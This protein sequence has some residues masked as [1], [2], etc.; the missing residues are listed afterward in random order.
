MH[1]ILLYGRTLEQ[2]LFQF[3]RGIWLSMA[4]SAIILVFSAITG[5]VMFA[6]FYDCDPLLNKEIS[7]PDQV[8]SSCICY[9]DIRWYFHFHCIAVTIHGNGCI[10]WIPRFAWALHCKCVFRM[11]KVIRLTGDCGMRWFG[12]L[13]GWLRVT[14]LIYPQHDVRNFTLIGWRVTTKILILI[15]SVLAYRDT[16]YWI[17]RASLWRYDM[18]ASM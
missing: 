13:S 10:P 4:A 9:T 12:N 15:F 5:F 2:H 18:L 7:A 16:E 11:F 8:S 3:C 17:L 1:T 14:Q 6:Y